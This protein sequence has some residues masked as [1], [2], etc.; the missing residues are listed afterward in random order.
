MLDCVLVEISNFFQ[1]RRPCPAN[2]TS[3]AQQ[4]LSGQLG[5][6]SEYQKKKKKKYWDEEYLSKKILLHVKKTLAD[7]FSR[8][9]GLYADFFDGKTWQ[10]EEYRT[11]GLHL[12]SA[13]VSVALVL[14]NVVRSSSTIAFF[15]TGLG[16]CLCYW[17][18]ICTSMILPKISRKTTVLLPKWRSCSVALF[19][20][21]FRYKIFLRIRIG[22]QWR[23]NW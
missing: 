5:G 7:T 4:L 3:V 23:Q 14:I 20:W 17:Y 21:V 19:W 9:C 8:N 15:Q 12:A 18:I 6:P 13:F 16:R 11:Y 22:D 2:K 10:M 1:P